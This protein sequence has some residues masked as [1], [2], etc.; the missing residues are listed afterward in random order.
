[1]SNE[2]KI[3][4]LIHKLGLKYHLTDEETKQIV[5]SQFE[6]TR[7]KLDELMKQI[8]KA[9]DYS[10]VEDL[11]KVFHFRSFC[12]FYIDEWRLKT[13]LKRKKH[14]QKVNDRKRT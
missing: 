7:E 8:S 2:G 9:N 6:F 4:Q 3:K 5:E 12:K 14:I 10:E 1:M 11:P 13:F